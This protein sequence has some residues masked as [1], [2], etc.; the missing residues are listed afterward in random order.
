MQY[1]GHYHRHPRRRRYFAKLTLHEALTT[2]A[3]HYSFRYVGNIIYFARGS[4]DRYINHSLV[5]LGQKS[6]FDRSRKCA[7]ID[8]EFQASCQV[9][10]HLRWFL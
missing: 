2:S 9:T 5:V 4:E 7:V 10:E 6:L 1:T 8:S 3:E